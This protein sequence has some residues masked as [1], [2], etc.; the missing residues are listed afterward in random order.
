MYQFSETMWLYNNFWSAHFGQK[1]WKIIGRYSKNHIGSIWI[2][3]NE[4]KF[5][6]HDYKLT[7]ITN[8]DEKLAIFVYDYTLGLMRNA[9]NNHFNTLFWVLSHTAS[10]ITLFKSLTW[11]PFMWVYI[12]K[13]FFYFFII[14]IGSPIVQPLLCQLVNAHPFF[15]S[16]AQPL[17]SLTLSCMCALSSCSVVTHKPS[18]CTHSR[19]K[20]KKPN[21]SSQ[22]FSFKDSPLPS[23]RL[24]GNVNYLKCHGEP[25]PLF[26]LNIFNNNS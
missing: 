23:L 26:R 24:L 2:L 14:T 8:E 9:T 20:K 6:K 18:L 13:H 12:F 10:H 4:N 5:S 11:L 25:L 22:E 17:A 1:W 15:N 7:Y 3:I 21:R 16:F 19:W